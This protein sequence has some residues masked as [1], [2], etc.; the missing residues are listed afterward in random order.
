ME[1][2]SCNT[3]VTENTRVVFT[4]LCYPNSYPSTVVRKPT[5]GRNGR[6]TSWRIFTVYMKRVSYFEAGN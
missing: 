4:V 1:I 5:Y 2:N 6:S 3:V